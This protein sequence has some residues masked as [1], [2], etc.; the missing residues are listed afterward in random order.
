MDEV[1]FENLKE[2]VTGLHLD[3]A[4]VRN[5]YIY[6]PIQRSKTAARREDLLYH[7]YEWKVQ[8]CGAKNVPRSTDRG[9]EVLIS[10]WQGDKNEGPNCCWPGLG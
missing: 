2:Q 5:G 3:R 10:N 8:C 9:M 7:P 6:P 4:L 1:I